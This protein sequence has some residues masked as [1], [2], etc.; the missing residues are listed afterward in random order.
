MNWL[1]NILD[2]FTGGGGLLAPRIGSAW[3]Y[4]LICVVV[5]MIGRAIYN[6]K[7]KK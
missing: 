2:I 5:F 7:G 1:N 6:R 3:F 4:L